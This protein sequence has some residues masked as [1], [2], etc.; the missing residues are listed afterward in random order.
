MTR[1]LLPALSALNILLQLG[2]AH[3][4]KLPYPG[5]ASYTLAYISLF[6]LPG[7]LLIRL[8]LPHARLHP[9]ARFSI[10]LAV[11]TGA[12]A[13][14]ILIANYTHRLGFPALLYIHAVWQSIALL[15]TCRRP[16][17]AT[18]TTSERP[19]TSPRLIVYTLV[20]LPVLGAVIISFAAFH[21]HDSID[22]RSETVSYAYRIQHMRDYPTTA[23]AYRGGTWVYQQAL[24][25]WT[26]QLESYDLTQR[27]SPGP[28]ML[29]AFVALFALAYQVTQRS[30]TAYLSLLFTLAVAFYDTV[31]MG[32]LSHINH[33]D[34]NRLLQNLDADH[35]MNAYLFVLPAITLTLYLLDTSQPRPQK[36]TG[37]LKPHLRAWG[38]CPH[39]LGWLLVIIVMIA[40][41]GT[42][43]LGFGQY[44]MIVGGYL[45]LG[46]LT[47]P[48]RRALRT[49]IWGGLAMLP[50]AILPMHEII[51]RLKENTMSNW[52][53]FPQH[54]GTNMMLHI[55]DR[56]DW[57]LHPAHL[58]PPLILTGTMLGLLMLRR[59]RHDRTARYIGAATLFPL[60]AGY[61]PYLATLVAA[62]I[63]P[64]LMD[65]LLWLLPTGLALAYA[66]HL[67]EA[68][69]KDLKNVSPQPKAPAPLIWAVRILPLLIVLALLTQ[70]YSA[71]HAELFNL[72][73]R[74]ADAARSTPAMDELVEAL[75][76]LV[77]PGQRVLAPT[78]ESIYL[79]M[80]LSNIY[81]SNAMTH[82]YAS[83]AF[84]ENPWGGED[85][86][87]ML[88]D[89]KAYYIV[90]PRGSPQHTYMKMH[91]DICTLMQETP[92]YLIYMSHFKWRYTPTDHAMSIVA[93]LEGTLDTLP[94][95]SA[96][97]TPPGD[98]ASWDTAMARFA[99]ALVR[100]PDNN[101]AKYGLAYTLLQSGD[102]AR[103]EDFYRNLLDTF[104]NDANVRMGLAAALWAQAREAEALEVLGTL[105]AALDTPYLEKLTPTQT[106]DALT[107]WTHTP[108]TTDDARILAAR[109]L[110]RRADPGSALYV[111]E[112]I[113]DAYRR[114]TDRRQIG[115]LYTTLGKPEAA[116]AAFH[117][118]GENAD[119]YHLLRGH[120]AMAAGDMA[121]ARSAY[122]AAINAGA[123][124]EGWIYLGQADPDHA[125]AHYR[126]AGGFWGTAA[127]YALYMEQGRSAEA[128]VAYQRALS[129]ASFPPDAA[130]TLISPLDTPALDIHSRTVQDGRLR[131]TL[132]WYGVAPAW[133]DLKVFNETNV[134]T[135]VSRAV[136]SPERGAA[137]WIF[138][139]DVQGA[140]TLPPRPA[141]VEVRQNDHIYRIGRVMLAPPAPPNSEPTVHTDVTFGAQLKLYGYTLDVDTGTLALYWEAQV[142]PPTD[143]KVFV[144]VFD[145]EGELA[146][147][148]DAPPGGYP[149]SL[150]EAGARTMDMYTLPLPPGDHHILLGLY[151]AYT[152]ERLRLPDGRD[153]IEIDAEG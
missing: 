138:D 49:L 92:H 91:A 128:E 28:L 98:D 23:Q 90:V 67:V 58:T 56:G 45:T 84:Y 142:P 136:P 129:T 120:L 72:A 64:L 95:Q 147:Q 97:I 60:I 114:P 6:I 36:N 13:L 75:Q 5:L 32:Y 81:V 20:T 59:A 1:K 119:L 86:I 4:A 112:S 117:A 144:H 74:P 50:F 9:T 85:Y 18:D 130:P 65:R 61:T 150:W 122:R 35:T 47:H 37:G 79:Y 126:T 15:W 83:K 30:D 153:M 133:W 25:A 39:T 73:R 141:T 40:V 107:A 110:D 105:R 24:I 96:G 115:T 93:Q 131:L 31:D 27:V 124:A 151:E 62:I 42:H 34:D 68:K 46:F 2:L 19:R 11:G 26:G 53:A 14:P 125:E 108:H 52:D 77:L 94:L 69:V 10:G 103:A 116:L 140:D 148:I 109:L 71:V 17:R 99:E 134:Y 135:N 82:F 146:A 118:D 149:S 63:H 21:L 44:L 29:M 102:P 152:L 66:C 51:R 38:L 113:P 106:A 57:I 48:S 145:A 12:L 101:Y 100:A 22:L 80:N 41:V 76:T 16:H 89:T 143:L 139:I 111:L 132:R 137:A 55:N 70:G 88:H 123:G 78:E 7:L 121:A 3:G 127:L 8:L 43:P 87:A 104:P 33:L 54:F